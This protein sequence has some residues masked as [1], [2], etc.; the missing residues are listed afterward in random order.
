MIKANDFFVKDMSFL[1]ICGH[2][3]QIAILKKTVARRR[4][5]HAYLF[6]GIGGIGKKTLALSFV[7]ALNCQ[8]KDADD[9]CGKCSSCLKMQRKTH[10]DLITVEPDGQFIRIAAI[11]EIQEQMKIKPLEGGWRGIIIDEADKLREEAANALL[12]TLEEPNAFNIFILICSRPH[13]LLP[14][15]VSRCRQMRFHPLATATVVRFLQERRGMDPERAALLAGLSGGSIGRALDMNKEGV[16]AYRAKIME[17]IGNAS[18]DDPLSL[19]VFASFLGEDKKQIMQGLDILKTCFRDA[20]I[21]KETRKNEMLINVDQFPLISSLAEQLTGGQ[22]IQNIESVDRAKK[23]IEQNVNK[24]LTLE[25]M[26][27]NLNL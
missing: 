5:S 15:I 10:P 22:I 25:A 24:A 7:K 26:A 4:A 17:L 12:K 23:A 9:A 2:A 27:F 16:D 6:S 3:G 14:T 20:L 21:L 19:L 11:R 1:E 18:K 13:Y 8:Q